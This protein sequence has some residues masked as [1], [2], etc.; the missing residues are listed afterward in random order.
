MTTSRIV[1]DIYVD[2]FDGIVNA[3]NYELASGFLI[4]D[5]EKAIPFQLVKSLVRTNECCCCL[6]QV[7][8]T[9]GI[10]YPLSSTVINYRTIPSIKAEFLA[11]VSHKLHIRLIVI[12]KT[13]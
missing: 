13:Y 10:S 1:H 2:H 11:I 12:V 7:S 4:D 6:I 3:G 8:Y 9:I 5:T